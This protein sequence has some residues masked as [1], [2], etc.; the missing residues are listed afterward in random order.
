MEN[1]GKDQVLERVITPCPINIT[2]YDFEKSVK[3]TKIPSRKHY[4]NVLVVNCPSDS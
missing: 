1:W 2:H 3:E 4:E